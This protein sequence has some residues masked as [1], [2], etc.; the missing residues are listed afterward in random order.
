[1]KVFYSD[2]VKEVRARRAETKSE[3]EGLGSRMHRGEGV[4]DIKT[5][6]V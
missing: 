6:K 1:V 5:D 3:M 2:V 4:E